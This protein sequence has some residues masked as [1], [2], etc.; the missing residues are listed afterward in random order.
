M[1][2]ILGAILDEKDRSQ[3]SGRASHGSLASHLVEPYVFSNILYYQEG[4]H[5]YAPNYTKESI[6][7]S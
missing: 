4:H 7:L 6:C 5:I 3:P 2:T 1:D